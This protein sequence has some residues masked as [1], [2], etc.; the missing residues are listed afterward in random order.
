[1]TEKATEKV[2]AVVTTPD[3]QVK[4]FSGDTIILFTVKELIHTTEGDRVDA[5]S[6]YVGSDIQDDIFEKVIGNLV[7]SFIEK[8]VQTIGKKPSEAAYILHCVSEIL[9][10]RSKK[11]IDGLS[12]EE[13]KADLEEELEELL[14]M[15]LN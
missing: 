7:G 8:R 14:K 9:E 4:T 12:K 15:I 10:E 2:A 6:V 1:M 5:N 13:L 11:I 3:G